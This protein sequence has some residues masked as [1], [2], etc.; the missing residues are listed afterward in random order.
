MQRS[1]HVAAVQQQL[2]E[3]RIAAKGVTAVEAPA[4]KFLGVGDRFDDVAVHTHGFNSEAGDNVDDQAEDVAVEPVAASPDASVFE[5]VYEDDEEADIPEN[6]HNQP[7]DTSADVEATERDLDRYQSRSEG[8]SSPSPPHD[9]MSAPSATFSP[10]IPRDMHASPSEVDV[11]NDEHVD[12]HA[13]AHAVDDVDAVD[14][15]ESAEHVNGAFPPSANAGAVKEDEDEDE[16]DEDGDGERALGEEDHQV[17][18]EEEEEEDVEEEEDDEDAEDSNVDNDGDD[19]HG[20]VDDEDGATAHDESAIAAP[21]DDD[22]IGEYDQVEDGED[23]AAMEVDEPL[24]GDVDDELEAPGPIEDDE[25]EDEGDV[26]G[27]DADGDE[28]EDDED[29]DED[30]QNALA[31]PSPSDFTA[32]EAEGEENGRVAVDEEDEDEDDVVVDEEED[33]DDEQGHTDGDDDESTANKGHVVDHEE[34]G[35]EEEEDD[36]DDDDVAHAGVAAK[37]QKGQH[38]VK[39]KSLRG[40]S[41]G[42]GTGYYEDDDDDDEEEEEDPDAPSQNTTPAQSVAQSSGQYGKRPRPVG[43]RY[44]APSRTLATHDATRYDEGSEDAGEGVDHGEDDEEYEDDD[45]DDATGH[46]GVGKGKGKSVSRQPWGKTPRSGVYDPVDGNGDD[47]VHDVDV[48]DDDDDDETSGAPRGDHGAKGYKSGAYSRSSATPAGDEVVEI[49]DEEDEHDADDDGAREQVGLAS[50]PADHEYED[51]VEDVDIDGET[52]D[53]SVVDGGDDHDTVQY[54]DNDDDVIDEDDAE[55]VDATEGGGVDSEYVD[56][57]DDED[58]GVEADGGNLAYTA[59]DSDGA[60]DIAPVSGPD[61][62]QVAEGDLDE[63]AEDESAGADDALDGD[64]DEDAG[65]DAP[66]GSDTEL[67]HVRKRQRVE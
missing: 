28:E 57:E 41:N 40:D 65:G 36:D 9:H 8:Q 46:K 3:Q 17:D 6:H 25:D 66:G 11:D 62:E 44:T 23:V 33:D 16:E 21:V 7:L 39:G 67:A 26:H 29:E 59:E 30:H 19:G 4:T 64:D 56:D 60:D 35:E 51:G 42:P 55:E 5:A 20:V 31:R 54:A 15:Y 61:G 24:D 47:E 37:G 27:T 14:E 12:T 34:D 13:D 53:V 10:P 1:E 2:S 58:D 52:G 45:D 22:D 49:R 32:E 48:D 50:E 38:A 18:E 43:K 63:N